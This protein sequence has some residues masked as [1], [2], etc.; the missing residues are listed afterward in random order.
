MKFTDVLG[1]NFALKNKTKKVNGVEIEIKGYLDMD[2]FASVIHTIADVCYVAGDYRA[3]NREIARRYAILKY[4]TNLEVELSEIPEIFKSSQCGDWFREIEKEVTSLPIWAEVEAA[5]DAQVLSFPTSFDR[6]CN[7]ISDV[8]STDQS[9][10]LS[11]IKEVLESLS[12]IDKA[13]FVEA[14][15]ENNLAKNKGGDENGGEKS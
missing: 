9:A 5:V 3:E 14:T 12:K 4:M 11:D 6:L 1:K 13:E 2:A 10:N 7:K 8:I 15:I